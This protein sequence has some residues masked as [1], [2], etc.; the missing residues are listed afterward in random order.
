MATLRSLAKSAVSPGWFWEVLVVDNNS[1]DSTRSLVE[2]FIGQGNPNFRYAFEPRQGKSFALNTGIRSAKGNIVAMT[3]DDCIVEPDWISSI[4]RECASDPTVAIIGGRVELY[5]E[6]DEPVTV[7]VSRERRVV[8]DARFEPSAPPIIGCNIA[9]RREVF[10]TIGYFDKDL[11][12]GSRRGLVSEDLDFVY[13][14]CRKGFRTIYSP[15]VL[16][17]HNHG[18]RT[19]AD[20]DLLMRN[21]LRGRGAFYC[22][23]ILRADREVL[24]LAYWEILNLVRQTAKQVLSGEMV[25]RDLSCLSSLLRGAVC[26]LKEEIQPRI[27]R[28]KTVS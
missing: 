5:N 21:Y 16:V 13:R 24:K 25:I 18:R 8:S 17:Y 19:E 2:T 3:D 12:P 7:R 22:K 20:R 23:H 4:F 11:G 9:F 14:A 28:H 1:T 6:L 26:R 15:D 10:D 27:F